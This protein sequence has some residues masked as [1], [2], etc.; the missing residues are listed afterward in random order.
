MCCNS[1]YD[2]YVIIWLSEEYQI[3]NSEL[4]QSF[5][6]YLITMFVA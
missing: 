5:V 2:I 6:L 3:I 1:E 4:Q